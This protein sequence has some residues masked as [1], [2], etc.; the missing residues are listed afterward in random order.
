[1]PS[2]AVTAPNR[3]RRSAD[4]EHRDVSQVPHRRVQVDGGHACL[5]ACATRTRL[6]DVAPEHVGLDGDEHDDAD[7]HQLV[8]GIDVVEVQGVANH[9]DRERP[10][11]R[12]PD[13]AAAACERGAADDHSRDRVELGKVA[14]RRR[15]AVDEARP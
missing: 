12:I 8:E 10:D 14:G 5:V 3:L 4:G 15:A 13:V 1:M 7:R 11:E 6:F 9:A 2:S